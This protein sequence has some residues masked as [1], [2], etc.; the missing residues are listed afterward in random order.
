MFGLWLTLSLQAWAEEADREVLWRL[1][2]LI[3]P[4]TC[5]IL[6]SLSM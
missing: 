6:K 2:I 4:K 1:C 5:I 3:T